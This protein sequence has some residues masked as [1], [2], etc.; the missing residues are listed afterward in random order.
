LIGSITFIF[1]LVLVATNI[2]QDFL[3]TLIDPR[4]GYE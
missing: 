4:I 2:L 3:Y 1:I